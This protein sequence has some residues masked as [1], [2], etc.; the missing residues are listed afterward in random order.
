MSND[1]WKQKYLDQ[2]DELE[3][4]E[5][6]W[7][8]LEESLRQFISHLSL[9]ASDSDKELGKKLKTL[10]AAIRKGAYLPGDVTPS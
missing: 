1:N 6:T 9:A 5:R 8:Q 2:L 3:N 7:G 10:R 4:Q